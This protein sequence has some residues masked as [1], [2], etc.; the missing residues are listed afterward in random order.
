MY[1]RCQSLCV[2]DLNRRVSDFNRCVVISFV[3]SDQSTAITIAASAITI[4]VTSCRSLRFG[5]CF[6]DNYRRVVVSIS[7]INRCLSDYNRCF[8]DGNR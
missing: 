5:R 8:S 7:D 1:Q 4:A 6:G 3:A 2:G